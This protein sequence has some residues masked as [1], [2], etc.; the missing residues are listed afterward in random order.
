MGYSGHLIY[1]YR[2][3]DGHIRA[4]CRLLLLLLCILLLL[5]VAPPFLLVFC[6]ILASFFC[7]GAPRQS[8]FFP[9]PPP[10]GFAFCPSHIFRIPLDTFF[11]SFLYS[12]LLICSLP[13]THDLLAS[14]AVVQF[15]IASLANQPSCNRCLS[16]IS[17]SSCLSDQVF[18]GLCVT[19]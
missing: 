11:F 19:C 3:W 4:I 16:V 2:V 14:S 18:P 9:F 13:G 15:I 1:V 8:L 10:S 12:L 17:H 5:P 6:S 7:L